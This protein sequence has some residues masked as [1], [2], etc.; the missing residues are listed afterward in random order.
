MNERQTKLM[1]RNLGSSV[2]RNFWE[3]RLAYQSHQ[4]PIDL[5]PLGMDREAANQSATA[6]RLGIHMLKDLPI[7]DDHGKGQ[8]VPILL[9]IE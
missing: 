4:A 1:S 9:W 5:G 7:R 8:R 2:S 6:R 3:S